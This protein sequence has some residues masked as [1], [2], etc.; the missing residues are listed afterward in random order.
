MTTD[1]QAHGAAKV[2]NRIAVAAG[3]TV[4]LGAGL[5]CVGW[6]ASIEPLRDP[7][8]TWPTMK[9]NLAIGLLL[10]GAAMVA[11]ARAPRLAAAAGTAV[12]ALGA[13]TLVQ[14]LGGVS[15]GIL[16]R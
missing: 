10:L 7:I 2:P 11:Y 12:T 1:K 14:D 15:F 6:V 5:A 9:L 13:I 8:D 16:E 3:L 4:M